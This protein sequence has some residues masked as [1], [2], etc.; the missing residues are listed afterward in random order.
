MGCKQHLYGIPEEEIMLFKLRQSRWSSNGAVSDKKLL[1]KISIQ[2][3]PPYS[4][5]K[6]EVDF[7]L[8]GILS[9]EGHF[10]ENLYQK[11]ARCF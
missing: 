7:R 1:W 10:L 2:E 5:K 9:H 8:A 6:A 4:A 11:F 3:V